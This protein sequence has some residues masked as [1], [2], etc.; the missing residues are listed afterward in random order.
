M[1]RYTGRSTATTVVKGKPTLLGFKIWTYHVFVDNLFS[2]PLL[3]RKLHDHRYKATGTARPNC[4]IHK[5]LKR[6]RHSIK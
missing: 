1:V 2:T 3:L 6:I 5:D 4:G